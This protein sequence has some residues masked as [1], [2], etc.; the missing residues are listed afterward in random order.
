MPYGAREIP[1]GENKNS[2]DLDLSR[3]R[4]YQS[5]FVQRPSSQALWDVAEKMAIT[6]REPGAQK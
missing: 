5:G 4:V 2:C 1:A 3:M 6:P